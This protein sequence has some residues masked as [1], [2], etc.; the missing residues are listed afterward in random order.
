MRPESFTLPA[1]HRLRGHG[2]SVV[3]VCLVRAG[4]FREQLPSGPRPCGPGEVRV[5]PA[6]AL[7]AL[8]V[9]AEGAHGEILE[10]DPAVT[11]GLV[12]PLRGTV[13][14]H[15]D[16]S[17]PVVARLDAAAGA[18]DS[19][20]TECAALELVARALHASPRADPP[21]WL[22]DL[23]ADLD[24]APL[25]APSLRDCAARHARHR[26]H[27]ANAFRRW[28]GRSLGA[29]VRARR[30]A[31]AA[32]ALR[33]TDLPL[34]ALAADL[35]FADQAHFT[36]AFGARFGVPPARFRRQARHE[37]GATPVQDTAGT[38]PH[39]GPHPVPASGRSR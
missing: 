30:L 34:A 16:G 1:D 31:A 5:S 27:T 2:H 39:T 13:F 3:H 37:G 10:L 4:G 22:S 15:P 9:G 38:V 24:A 25:T 33:G 17:A 29:H 7:H 6:G 8:D 26:T 12:A 23:R 21:R 32:A 28:F 35:G 36:R 14:L 11:A 20:R 19:F 18:A